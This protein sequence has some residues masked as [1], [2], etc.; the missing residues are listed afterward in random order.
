MKWLWVVSKEIHPTTCKVPACQEWYFMDPLSVIKKYSGCSLHMNHSV[1]CVSWKCLLSDYRKATAG[2]CTWENAN[3]EH[4]SWLKVE[5][6]WQE[7]QYDLPDEPGP[8]AGREGTPDGLPQ[9]CQKSGSLSWD[10]DTVARKSIIHVTADCAFLQKQNTYGVQ[11]KTTKAPRFR[12][13]LQ[14]SSQVP[15]P[16]PS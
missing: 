8:F 15:P 6:Q 12:V 3:P 4:P 14:E 5:V 7:W 11:S 9:C 1:Q 2:W 16:P 10:Q 13:L